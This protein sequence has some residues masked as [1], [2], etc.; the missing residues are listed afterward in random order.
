MA[1]Y[2][3]FKSSYKNRKGKTTATKTYYV[4]FRD[5]RDISRRLPAFTSKQASEEMGRSLVRLVEYHKGSG[6]QVDPSLMTWLAGL[7]QTTRAK[8]V[9]I[10]L[11]HPEKAAASKPLVDHLAD[12]QQS[13][14]AKDCS[15]RHVDLVVSRTRKL[16]DGCRFVFY[17]D[18]DASKVPALLHQWRQDTKGKKGIS[19]QTY[20]F[21]LGSLK[22][23][24][25]WMIKD[26]RATENPVNHL[27]ALNVRTD[28]RHDRRPFTPD[29][30]RILLPAT[31]S[32]PV[33]FKMAG[34]DRYML[35]WLAAETG[36]R[37][38]EL[39]SLTRASFDLDT[40]S[41]SVTVQA[42]YSKR[43]RQDTIPLRPE[44]TAALREFLAGKMPAAPAFPTMPERQHVCDM[45][46]LDVEAAGIAYV[47]DSGR[48]AD[49]H[50]LRHTFI[51]NLAAAGVHPRT[52]QELARH[53]D[54]NLTMSRYS[55][56]LRDQ[57]ADAIAV[58]PDLNKPAAEQQRATGTDG[59]S[60]N[61]NKLPARSQK[62]NVL[63][64][65]SA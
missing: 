51:S 21:Y 1:R 65:C 61:K 25:R 36:L 35:Y 41:P 27:D 31:R 62:E 28:R 54:I 9:E 29:E 49:F 24:C 37:Q 20:N 60:A 55:H 33:R 47:D 3:V 18:I 23:F 4:E 7:P 26:R 11:L 5:Q 32:G 42:S 45:F 59:K 46:R 40:D 22:Q 43:R 2:R 14:R 8:L 52:A 58:L 17:S 13:L 12:W 64:L 56:V 50:A 44:I 57:M 10:G 34:E 38:N 48:Y 6:G 39:R 16:I 63:A 15:A 30:L 19:A 53:S